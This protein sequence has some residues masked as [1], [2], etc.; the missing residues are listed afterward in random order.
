M[1]PTVN[2]KSKNMGRLHDQLVDRLASGVAPVKRVPSALQQWLLWMV[3]SLAVMGLFLVMIHVQNNAAQVFRQMP[4]LGFV[5]IAFAGAALA[6]WEAI[7][8][9]MPGRQPRR[10]TVAFSLAVLAV[11]VAF[12]FVFF[13]PAGEKF[14]LVGAFLSGSECAKHVWMVGLLPW[15]LMGWILSRNASFHPGWTG[16]WSGASAFL[17]GTVTVQIHCSSWDACHMLAAHLLPVALMT[18]LS[19]FLGAFWFSRWRK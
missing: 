7:A 1:K 10:S 14:D 2:P 6:A 12:P 17:M 3:L 15:A 18:F 9:S 13:Y 19:T 16:A 5:L 4:P 8:S 11:L